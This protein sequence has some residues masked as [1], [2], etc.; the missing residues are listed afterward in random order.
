MFCESYR[1]PLNNAACS[2]EA[3]A[4]ELAAHLGACGECASAFAS[5]QALFAAI[6][7]SLGVVANAE[8]PPS[9]LPGVRVRLSEVTPGGFFTSSWIY[10]YAVVAAILIL[11]ATAL[12]HRTVWP[13]AH[14]VSRSAGA[15]NTELKPV[16]ETKSNPE[17]APR[18]TLRRVLSRKDPGPG[19]MLLAREVLV[20]GDERSGL[21]RLAAQLRARPELAIAYANLAP[22][23]RE[24]ELQIPPIEIDELKVEP[25]AEGSN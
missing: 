16:F 22:T 13:P 1:Q 17:L 15:T 5:E 4:P 24:D 20:P 2:G 11:T 18:M 19:N 14:E 6:E 10:A 7:R 3:L 12:V 21:A 9:L 23:N 25:I 8:A